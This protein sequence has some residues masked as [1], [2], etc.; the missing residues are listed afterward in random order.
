MQGAQD[1]TLLLQVDFK[2]YLQQPY[3][4]GTVYFLIRSDD[5]G[6]RAFDLVVAIYQQT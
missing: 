4:T 3:A 5:L 1:W 6:A 2:D